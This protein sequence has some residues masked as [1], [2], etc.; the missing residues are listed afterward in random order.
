ML[1]ESSGDMASLDIREHDSEIS[2]GSRHA[3]MAAL[4]DLVGR[5]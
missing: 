4:I 3:G 5:K 2:E 1:K